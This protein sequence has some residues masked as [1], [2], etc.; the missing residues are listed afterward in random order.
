MA[1]KLILCLYML[2][3]KWIEEALI[4]P[5]SSGKP[6]SKIWKVHFLYMEK[7]SSVFAI[8]N[9]H[10]LVDGWLLVGGRQEV[11]GMGNET[12]FI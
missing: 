6:K 9:G 12:S 5:V 3:A 8:I 10:A 11:L 7:R 1:K 2:T 4:Q